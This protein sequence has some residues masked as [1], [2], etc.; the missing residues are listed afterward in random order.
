MA[1]DHNIIYTLYNLHLTTEYRGGYYRH[2]LYTL[3]HKQKHLTKTS[4][5]AS[6]THLL[7]HDVEDARCYLETHEEEQVEGGDTADLGTVAR[8]RLQQDK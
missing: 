2:I 3:R 1:S 4:S 5:T 6:R 7:V 8:P